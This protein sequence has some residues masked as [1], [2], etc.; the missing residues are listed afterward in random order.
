MEDP[1]IEGAALGWEGVGKAFTLG[2]TDD[3]EFYLKILEAIN[4]GD[5]GTTESLTASV[6]KLYLH[7]HARCLAS[8][9]RQAAQNK[10][11]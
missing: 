2:V 3:L 11:R 9:D 6:T 10:V 1:I 8:D 5:S 7:I 4:C